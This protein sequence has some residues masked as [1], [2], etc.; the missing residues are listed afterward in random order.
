MEYWSKTLIIAHG[1]P[2]GENK[3]NTFYRKTSDSEEL[4]K[5]KGS[6]PVDACIHSCTQQM[7]DLI[8]KNVVDWSDLISTG[9]SDDDSSQKRADDEEV[10]SG[11]E[12]KWERDKEGDEMDEEFVTADS[13]SQAASRPVQEHD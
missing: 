2:N 9:E 3:P 5:A 11:Y 10:H 12:S 6:E 1:R 7:S 13:P 8:T 4:S